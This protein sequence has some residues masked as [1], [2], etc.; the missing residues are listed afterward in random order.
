M[1]NT[2]KQFNKK[3]TTVILSRENFELVV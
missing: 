2:Q 1:Y 3:I